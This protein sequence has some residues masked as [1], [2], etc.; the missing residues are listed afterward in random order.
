[1]TNSIAM[2]SISCLVLFLTVFFIVFYSIKSYYQ[3]KK[4]SIRNGFLLFEVDA[5]LKRVRINNDIEILNYIPEFIIDLQVK[6]GEWFDINLFLNFFDKDTKK[7]LVETINSKDK[8]ISKTLLN[9]MLE[10]SNNDVTYNLSLENKNSNMFLITLSW[11]D[12]F[13]FSINKRIQY[14]E[15]QKSFELIKDKN[16]V[17]YLHLKLSKIFKIKYLV[18]EIASILVKKKIN[19]R[20]I[21][22]NKNENFFIYFEN[23]AIFN[24]LDIEIQALFGYITDLKILNSYFDICVLID[25]AVISEFD[26]NR[27]FLLVAY[28]L[29]KNSNEEGKKLN[30][31][32][33]NKD[34]LSLNAFESFENKYLNVIS[35]INNG[36]YLV[37]NAPLHDFS[38]SQTSLKITMLIFSEEYL[39]EYENL[40]NNTDLQRYLWLV[41]FKD[42][43]KY[44]LTNSILMIEDFIF[45]SLNAKYLYHVFKKN[46]HLQI[47][48]KINNS[49]NYEHLISKLNALNEASYSA[50]IRINE[51]EE[52]LLFFLS[53]TNIQFIIINKEISK[54]LN[55]AKNIVSINMLM[56]YAND[57]GIILIFEE[58]N[59]ENYKKLITTKNNEKILYLN[60]QNK[61]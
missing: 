51:I 28:L 42:I 41:F 57:K 37:K 29:F 23:E 6:N 1:M 35:L 61:K 2:I 19:T 58:L 24:T 40:L 15:T 39:S 20:I 9:V 55:V 52:N 59:I 21:I 16:F 46:K 47:C 12:I 17:I 26:N 54:N 31:V 33:I 48:I 50:G 49:E 5:D 32:L 30:Y 53:K 36:N 44:K 7:I 43:D 34:A 14:I 56:S 8:E 45:P 13:S 22:V 3:I 25:K 11:E 60:A 10:G 4:N 18:N 27:F 38:S